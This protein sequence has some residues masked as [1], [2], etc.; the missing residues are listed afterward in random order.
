[1]MPDVF[2]KLHEV[3]KYCK[4]K[5]GP[6]EPGG[7]VAVVLNDAVVVLSLDGENGLHIN[8][9]AGTPDRLD[10]SLNLVEERSENHG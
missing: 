8:V 1:M 2:K 7:R 9:I 5:Y 6:L 3:L 10:I 4:E